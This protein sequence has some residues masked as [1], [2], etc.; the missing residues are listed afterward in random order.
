LALT[1]I[2]R[3]EPGAEVAL[4]AGHREVA[5]MALKGNSLRRPER[6]P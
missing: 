4:G 1:R 2:A 5:G 3:P 6:G